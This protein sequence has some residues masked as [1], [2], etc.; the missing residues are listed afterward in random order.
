MEPG[1]R[2]ERKPY[3]LLLGERQAVI[4]LGIGKVRID[5][6]GEFIILVRIVEV[7]LR[8]EDIR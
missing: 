1:Q 2:I 7:L 3:N 5:L 4:A 6:Q 8:L